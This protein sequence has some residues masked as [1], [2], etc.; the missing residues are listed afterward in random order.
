MTEESPPAEQPRPQEVTPPYAWIGAILIAAAVAG[1]WFIVNSP[2]AP[3]GEGGPADAGVGD[4]T[5]PARV[6]ECE[7]TG[8]CERWGQLGT[9]L[10]GH[11]LLLGACNFDVDC[12]D[13]NDCTSERCDA[14]VCVGASHPGSCE[15][16]GAGEAA[17]VGACYDDTCVAELPQ[18][19]TADDACADG[20]PPCHVGTCTN[21]ACS[22]AVALD[23]TSCDIASGITGSCNAG[24]CVATVDETARHV[25]CRPA[26][27]R[28]GTVEESCSPTDTRYRMPTADLIA[29]AA[30]VETRI[31]EGVLYDVHVSLVPLADGGYNIVL[32]NRRSRDEVAGL[33]DPSFVAF[34]IGGFTQS[35][36]WRSRLLQVWLTPY[37][38]GWQ[39]STEGG[40]H[41]L[42]RGRAASMLGFLG[43]VN[44]QAFRRWL[45]EAFEHIERPPPRAER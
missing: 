41:A 8:A 20:T 21:G 37:E 14:G 39:I 22:L 31:R 34:E 2:S 45:Q 35:S 38:D 18:A 9:C 26:Y 36:S 7:G 44:I 19:C 43:V 29:E 10:A 6:V 3:A 33:V 16:G 28:R 42:R 13:G 4:A 15:L 12:D 30:R 5:E 17:E 1:A 24:H 25:R 27:T 32:F 23:G 40:R 11:C